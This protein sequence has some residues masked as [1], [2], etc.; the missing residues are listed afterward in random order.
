MCLQFPEPIYCDCYPENIH[1]W[2]SINAVFYHE[3]TLLSRDD[4][5]QACTNTPYYLFGDVDYD[6]GFYQC[7]RV[8]DQRTLQHRTISFKKLY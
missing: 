3:W 8:I 5:G 6:Y 4:N 1:T 7:F 2:C